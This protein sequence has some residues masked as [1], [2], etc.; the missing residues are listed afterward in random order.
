MLQ[1]ER[2]DSRCHWTIPTKFIHLMI[3]RSLVRSPP[4][5]PNS[6]A[7]SW[8]PT[9]QRRSDFGH[10]P[11]VVA[12]SILNSGM[13]NIPEGVVA[14]AKIQVEGRCHCNLVSHWRHRRCH[15]H[16][17]RGNGQRP[18]DGTTF[19]ARDP[20]RRLCHCVLVA[21]RSRRRLRHNSICGLVPSRNGNMHNVFQGHVVHTVG[22]E[23]RD[24]V[25][26]YSRRREQER[27][28][29]EFEFLHC[30]HAALNPEGPALV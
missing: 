4:A 26:I 3:P 12:T 25:R 18:L 22:A 8:T 11:L 9:P 14:D 21:A 2:C 7:W 5:R 17:G 13:F 10:T 6:L 20:G 15:A 27:S 23:E 28:R 29:V 24:D 30:S 1:T 16:F 19:R